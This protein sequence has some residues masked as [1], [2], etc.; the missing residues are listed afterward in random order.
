MCVDLVKIIL[1]ILYKI[2][3]MFLKLILAFLH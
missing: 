1:R 2:E 3:H